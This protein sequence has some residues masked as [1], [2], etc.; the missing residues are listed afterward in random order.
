VTVNQ[1]TAS[2]VTAPEHNDHFG[3]Y[4]THNKITTMFGD[5]LDFGEV[6]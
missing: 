6:K 4:K 1:C 3:V 2:N 5:V